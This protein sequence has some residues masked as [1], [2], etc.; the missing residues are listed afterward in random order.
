MTVRLTKDEQKL[1]GHA[2]GMIVRYNKRRHAKGGIDTIYAFVLSD[3]GRIYD[4]A[5]LESST[6][7]GSVCAERVAIGN[8]LTKETPSS[9]I[10]CIVTFDPVP[11]RQ[12]HSSTPCGACRHVI[13]EHGDQNTTII[14]GQYMRK[15]GGWEFLPGMERYTTEELYPRPYRMVRWD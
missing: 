8:M 12:E 9:R 10:V 5:C 14:C 15:K 6:G 4:G 13:W 11:E 7:S 2:K 3:S 1:V